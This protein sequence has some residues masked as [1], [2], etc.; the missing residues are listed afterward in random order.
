MADKE[1]DKSRHRKQHINK[2]KGIMNKLFLAFMALAVTATSAFADEKKND[3][4][5]FTVVKEIPIT[6][7]KDQNQSG[8]CWCYSTLGFLEAELLRK[9]KGTFDLCESFVVH[10]TMTDR[11]EAA[12]RTHGDVSFSEGGSFYDVLYCMKNYGLVPQDAM[13]APGSL[14]GDSLFNFSELS[15]VAGAV[16][17]SIAKWK[18]EAGSRKRS[19]VLSPIWKKNV[20]AIYDNY[21]GKL[22]ESFKYEGK[23][24][25]PKSF[26][27]YLGLNADDY[28]SI[29]SY[30]HHPFY[31]PFVVEVQDNWRWAQSYNLP[32]NEMMQVIDNAINNGYTIA[33]G[34]D[35]SEAGFG[36]VTR[37]PASAKTKDLSHS[38]AARWT[39]IDGKADKN[40]V[41]AEGELTITQEMRQKA[42]DNWE[43]TDDHGMVIYGLAKDSTGA[44]YYMVKNSWGEYGKYKGIFYVSKPYVAYKTMNFVVNKNALPKEIAKKLGIKL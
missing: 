4:V 14:Q 10:H 25:T 11:A 22:P 26:A 32:L 2:D 19:L 33:W 6:S 21:L 34:A 36:A 43:T 1:A 18:P 40:T 9:G 13:P 28:V 20:E 30:T 41:S 5:K 37:V 29:S 42:Y 38:D 16:V 44:E 15:M 8:T 35:V 23:T 39:G 24:Y 3:T 12:V 17:N 7:I 31:E 27:E